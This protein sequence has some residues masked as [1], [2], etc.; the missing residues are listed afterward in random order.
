MIG[1][2][3]VYVCLSLPERHPI[4][5]YFYCKYTPACK[6]TPEIHLSSKKMGLSLVHALP[7]SVL[8]GAIVSEFTSTWF[9]HI[10]LHD[11]PKLISQPLLGVC[12][13][14]LAF[15]VYLSVN[16]GLANTAVP[17][18]AIKWI[19]AIIAL[20]IQFS[21]SL[22][23]ALNAVRHLS[24]IAINSFLPAICRNYLLRK[25]Q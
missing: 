24:L 5:G 13:T 3:F 19:G 1:H 4:H 9:T 7:V 18:V 8:W 11:G 21:K 10:T 6:Y 12:V 20:K 2:V 17:F 14:F 22:S 15:S 23:D 25:C 16:I